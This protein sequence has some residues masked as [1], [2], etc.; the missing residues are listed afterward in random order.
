[1]EVFI[2]ISCSFFK[3]IVES[4]IFPR[5]AVG[6]EIKK[7]SE[8][9]FLQSNFEIGISL[10]VIIGNITLYLRLSFLNAF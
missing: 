1:M 9:F 8:S 10:K 3:L 5:R 4:D 2:I 6:H 7:K